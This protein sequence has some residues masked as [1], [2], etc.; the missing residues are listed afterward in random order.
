VKVLTRLAGYLRE[1]TAFIVL[2]T[3]ILLVAIITTRSFL[4]GV[5]AD[6]SGSFGDEG[7]HERLAW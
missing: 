3:V 2:A 5:F 6:S 4:S 7:T 1:G